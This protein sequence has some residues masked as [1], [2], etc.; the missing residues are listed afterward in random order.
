MDRR[1]SIFILL[2]TCHF[3]NVNGQGAKL[4][5]IFMFLFVSFWF[6]EQ[7]LK[8]VI[9]LIWPLTSLEYPCVLRELNGKIPLKRKNGRC[10][11]PQGQSYEIAILKRHWVTGAWVLHNKTVE[12]AILSMD[13][14]MFIIVLIITLQYFEMLNE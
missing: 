5:R 13:N 7:S 2:E 9:L 8:S 11:N 10:K 1:T 4:S 12:L 6:L 14:N 3:R